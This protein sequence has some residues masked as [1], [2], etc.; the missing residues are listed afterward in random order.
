MFCAVRYQRG[1][2]G[3]DFIFKDDLFIWCP[4]VKR[5]LERLNSEVLRKLLLAGLPSGT[6]LGTYHFLHWTNC[7]QSCGLERILKPLIDTCSTST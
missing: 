3:V 7:S 5:D 4:E 1:A 6:V 2:S